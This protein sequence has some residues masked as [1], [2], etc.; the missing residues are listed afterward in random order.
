M[1]SR[2]TFIAQGT[3]LACASMFSQ[4]GWGVTES[5]EKMSQSHVY[6]PVRPEWLA[7]G[8]EQALEPKLSIIDAHHHFY[9][10][11][12]W[13]YLLNEYL[14]DASTHNIVG[15]VYMQALTHYRTSG[16]DYLK[17][18]GETHYVEEV[19]EP[20]R[21]QNLPHV[22]AGIIGYADLRRGAKVHEVLVAHVEAGKGRFRGIRHS[23]TWDADRTLLNPN[24]AAIPGLL[25]D[26]AYR[27][28]VAELARMKLSFDA[29]VFFPQLDELF[30][31]AKTFP[32][33]LFIINHCGGIARIGHYS[34]DPDG[35]FK[36]WSI[37]M[38]KLSELP[39]TFVKL[40]GL[41]MRVN[42][43]SFEKMTTPPSSIELANTWKPW[44][45]TC[46]EYFGTDRCMFGSNFPVDSGSYPFVNGWNAFK[47]LTL[48]MSKNNRHELFYDT[49]AKIYHLKEEGN[50][51]L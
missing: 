49:A 41:G 6:L 51:L 24:T 38:K 43:F 45:H 29:W 46:I 36:A 4:M 21:K 19:T 26:P 37:S 9:D 32:D 25:M 40:S 8:E 50:V 33:V 34:E 2:R 7:S 1:T 28:G 10:R 27:S 31:L 3:A 23:A 17:P 39:N 22:A 30:D 42:G 44:M 14:K 48:G 47:H 16:P 18:V 13:I 35:V 20:L 5:R 15:S 12:G 11:P